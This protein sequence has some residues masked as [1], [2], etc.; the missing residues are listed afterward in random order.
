MNGILQVDES[1]EEVGFIRTQAHHMGHQSRSSHSQSVSDA[2]EDSSDDAEMWERD[3]GVSGDDEECFV[4][5]RVGIVE[6]QPEGDDSA[7]QD[8]VS[9]QF[10]TKQKRPPQHVQHCL[11]GYEPTRDSKLW[12]HP[13]DDC[14]VQRFDGALPDVGWGCKDTRVLWA[15]TCSYMLS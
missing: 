8:G 6:G 1:H 2:L 12:L 10:G 9:S 4:Q 13:K 7:I 15:V 5:D 3:G 11:Q 14:V